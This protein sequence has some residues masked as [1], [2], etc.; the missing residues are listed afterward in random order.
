MAISAFGFDGSNT[1]GGGVGINFG[2]G[3]CGL[4]SV[5][6]VVAAVINLLPSLPSLLLMAFNSSALAVATEGSSLKSLAM[7]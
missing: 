2:L 3:G 1:S 5:L 4:S 6:V 7:K